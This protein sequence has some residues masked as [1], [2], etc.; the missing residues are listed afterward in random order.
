MDKLI[1]QTSFWLALIIS[2]GSIIFYIRLALIS[3]KQRIDSKDENYDFHLGLSIGNNQNKNQVFAY[4]LVAAGTSLSTVF[5]FFLTVSPFFGWLTFLCPIMFG[6]GNY[7]MFKVYSKAEKNEFFCEKASK[8]SGLTGLIPYLGETIT[9]SKMIGLFLVA[10]S[11]VNLLAFLILEIFIGADLISFLFSN[12]LQTQIS[13]PEN[14]SIWDFLIFFIS[15]A[16]LLSYV[17]IGGFRAVIL[18]DYWQM[19]T[20]NTT[21]IIVFI[22]LLATL[23]MRN[24]N[25]GID[26]SFLTLKATGITL[27]G[28]LI[29]IV[30]INIF[31]PMS[32]ESNWQRFRAFKGQNFDIKIAMTKSISN[33]V[34]LWIGLIFIA[35]FLVVL[36]KG[37]SLANITD[38]LK[39]IQSI[40]NVWFPLLVF[41]LFAAA[42]LFAMYST[43]DTC[44]S[45]LIYLIDYFYSFRY[46]EKHKKNK[47]ETFHKV[48][49]I[50][51]FIISILVYL[52]VH[53]WLHPNILQ[54]IFSVFSNL[55]VIAPTI[56]LTNYIKPSED[57]KINQIR[58]VYVFWSLAL[59][60]FVYWTCSI[61][62]LIKGAEFLWISQL[63][64]L[65]GLFSSGIPILL[66]L[67]RTTAKP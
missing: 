61:Y 41:P 13:T 62:S 7:I 5:V 32:Q 53:E 8:R 4:A 33:S 44:V 17:F 42:C 31:A 10:L 59:G 3:R 36:S 26:Y 48:C 66:L 20:M 12:T 58:K 35:F 34:I 27:S 51:I 29:N 65:A 9:G 67:N 18:S 56:L 21:I 28:F 60:S 22:S 39:A 45:A 57:K 40:D 6:I 55:V 47:I 2:I 43:A 25:S 14:F 52:L 37:A 23:F 54:L 38:V 64:I 19:K 49:M 46:P 24:W 63:A 1:T 15:I 30:L 16:G 50:F 11:F